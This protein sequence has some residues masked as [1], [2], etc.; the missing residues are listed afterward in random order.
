MINVLLI[1][2]ANNHD[3][4][5]SSSFCREL[6]EQ[7]KRFCVTVTENPSETLADRDKLKQY[8][9][10]LIDYNGPRW[11]ELAEG[12]F[13]LCV[14]NGTGVVFL[15]ASNNAFKGWT[16]YESMLGLAWETGVSGHGEFHEFEVD[17]VEQEHPVC[18]GLTRFLTFDELYHRMVPRHGVSYRT[19][20]TAYSALEQKGTGSHEPVAIALE[21]GKGR[22]FHLLLGHVWPHD[23]NGTHKGFGMYALE[24]QGFQTLFVRGC[25][26]SA[27]GE[28]TL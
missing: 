3:W 15:H 24:N 4:R 20:A 5:R 2:G 19:L 11:G 9:L 21:Y 26:W 27:T 22:I 12:N 13:G 14:N 7:T 1:T 18:K 28:V 17:I 6:L 10:F 23:F 16:A 25:E 8:G